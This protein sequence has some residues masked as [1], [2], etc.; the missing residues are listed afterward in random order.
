MSTPEDFSILKTM[1][2]FSPDLICALSPDGQ[3]RQVSDAWRRAL[4]YDTNEMIGRHISEIIHPDESTTALEKFLDAFGR[5]E[6]VGFESRCLGKDGQE[7]HI[8]WSA[9]RAATDELLICVGR[10]VT[11][12]RRAAE[13][14]REQELRHRTIIE[15]GF[16]MVGMVDEQGVYTYIGGATQRTLGYWPEELVGRLAFDFI[17]P[18]DRA[19]AEACFALLATQDVVTIPDFRFRTAGGEWRWLETSVNSYLQDG[20]KSYVVSSRDITA[21][22]LISLAHTESEQRFRAL[23]ESDSALAAF[24]GPDGHI[25]DANP[26]LLAFLNKERHEVLNL[27][28]AG[29]LP[30]E[31][32]ARFIKKREKAAS[33]QKTQF[34]ASV[35][36]AGRPAQ[37]LKVTYTP[38]VVEGAV[39][40]IY[41]TLRDVTEMA[42]ARHLIK[43]QEAQLSLIL[44]SIND[45]C[46]SL[47]NDWKLT[48]L[49]NEAER[50]M[51]IS[52]EGALGVNLWKLYPEKAGGIYQQHYQRAIDTGE[53][54]RF[55]AYFE[56]EKLWLDVKAYPFANGL[57]VFITDITKRVAN[58]KQ[59]KLLALVARGTDN[60]VL[61]TDARG[62]TEWV[63]EAFIKH[64]GYSREE[65]VGR[66]PGVVLQGPETDPTT[67]SFIRERMQRQLPFSATILNYKKSGQKLWFAIDVTPVHD[68]AG[69]LTQYVAIQQ[70]ITYRKEAE[71]SQAAMTQ[72]LYRHNRDLQQF[73]YVISHNL[74][75]P[76]A[77]ALGLA[78]VLTKLDKNSDVF[79][80][81]LTN[82]RQSMVQADDVL[83]DLNLVLSIRDKKDM[84]ALEPL[85]MR[86]VCQQAVRDLEEPLR[87]CDGNVVLN[88]E[89]QLVTR[90]NR[91]YLYSIFYNL[92]SNSIKY[93][94]EE[95]TL[96]VDIECYTGEH[97]GATITFTDNG[98]GFD[99]FKAGS[100]VFQLYKRFHTN[101]RGRGIGL[102]LVKTHVEAMGGKI[103]VASEV[104]FGTRFTIY[105]DKR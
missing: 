16:D 97:G 61:I 85:V 17:H 44:D 47:D 94:S 18:D 29:F 67:M 20:R 80:T 105:L 78:T 46:F 58:E 38:L 21:R 88:I 51:G 54:V 92:L 19:R 79:A 6:P 26:A 65:L 95:R 43:H 57:S 10:D 28:L 60:G 76:L 37:T 56:R 84:Q 86:D 101:Q 91:A 25:L 103:E 33:G 72:D 2:G 5:A 62:R 9:L 75:A 73:T 12:Q 89:D 27:V 96:Q 42:A 100:D 41:C 49:N 81:A 71:A 45:A 36:F 63:N 8:A 34:E 83:K 13:Q 24:I 48:Y 3:F 55:E 52:R 87:E 39:V 40:G 82:L 15:N 50:L 104:N 99:M 77:N 66:T 32:R 93:R 102:F 69:Q 22:K 70:N 68:E 64:T 4:G 7:V 90:G 31:V 11:Q 23:F 53:T 35:Q 14:A 98:S 1:M 74:R 59:L 30:E